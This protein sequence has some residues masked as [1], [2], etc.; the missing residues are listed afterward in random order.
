MNKIKYLINGFLKIFG[1]KMVR[2]IKEEEQKVSEE[3]P[4]SKLS[5]VEYNKQLWDNYARHWEKGG[6]YLENEEISEEGK[7]FFCQSIILD[8]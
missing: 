7:Q 8:E 5:N 4:D 1:C 2:V 3:L 6:V